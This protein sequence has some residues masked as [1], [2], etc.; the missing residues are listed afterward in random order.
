MKT[1]P[2]IICGKPTTPNNEC[3]RK[4]F[5]KT[6]I[7]TALILLSLPAFSQIYTGPGGST[8]GWSY[9][10]GYSDENIDVVAI[11]D[12]PIL[13]QG[14]S[15]SVKSL[16]IGWVRKIKQFDKPDVKLNLTPFLGG[17]YCITQIVN[18][19]EKNKPDEKL[20]PMAMLQLSIKSDV[21]GF[22]LSTSYCKDFYVGVGLIVFPSEL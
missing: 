6:L 4:C 12:M 16:S 22:Y 17:G 11:A 18:N 1:Y 20:Y 21:G 19:G 14:I 3:C 15:T 9:R 13:N 7:I 5:L 10:V 8:K 2:C